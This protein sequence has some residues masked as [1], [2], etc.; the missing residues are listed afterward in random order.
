MFLSHAT[1]SSQNC[2]TCQISNASSG[3]HHNTSYNGNNNNNNVSS[4]SSRKTFEV[5]FS[6]FEFLAA[7]ARLSSVNIEGLETFV[8]AMLEKAIAGRQN[9]PESVR[10][11]SLFPK[12]KKR[13][14]EKSSNFC[15]IRNQQ[16]VES[17]NIGPSNSSGN[18][19]NNSNSNN[20]N[21]REVLIFGQSSAPQVSCSKCRDEPTCQP[22]SSHPQ[23][24]ESVSSHNYQSLY[25]IVPNISKSRVTTRAATRSY[26]TL[27]ALN[28]DCQGE[29]ALQ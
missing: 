17:T 19:N 18:N 10:Q 26:T 12:Q 16:K 14:D 21:N 5:K 9:V 28:Q 29:L 24:P 22:W 15:T 27:E 7:S 4:S 8:A 13:D 23:S 11:H 6:A 2:N 3:C 1:S 25:Q 20:N